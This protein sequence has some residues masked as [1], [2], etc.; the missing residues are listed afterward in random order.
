MPIPK[1]K[2]RE[3][4]FQILY[5]LDMGTSDIEYLTSLISSEFH[6]SPR[7]VETALHS[8]KEILERKEALDEMISKASTSYDFE[9][10]QTIERNILRLGIYELFYIEGIPPKVAISEALRLSRK[11]ATPE[12]G[13]FINAILDQLYKNQQQK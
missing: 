6:I 1:Q 8:A 4:V 13:L 11:F 5:S 9:R 12:A 7:D 2:L 10:I 3:V